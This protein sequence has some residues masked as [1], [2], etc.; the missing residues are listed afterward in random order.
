VERKIVGLPHRLIDHLF[1]T[2]FSEFVGR[3]GEHLIDDVLRI[4]QV[5][6]RDG[7]GDGDLVSEQGCRLMSHRDAADVH[8]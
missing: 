7:P 8:E 5:G 4:V 3:Y 6:H 1:P 2:G